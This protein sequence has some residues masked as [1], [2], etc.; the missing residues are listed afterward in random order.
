MVAA[1]SQQS[2]GRILELIVFGTFRLMTYVVLAAATYIFA[3][4]AIKGGRTIFKASPPF[5]NLT[6]L[7][8]G[9][10]TLY[11]FEY[12]GKEDGVE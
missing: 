7:T 9:P 11:V 5:V 8:E 12:Q 6:F 1:N 2:R 3:D 4:I 10:Q